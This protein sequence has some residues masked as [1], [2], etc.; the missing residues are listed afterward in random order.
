MLGVL[1]SVKS[2]V[3]LDSVCIDNNVFRLHYKLTFAILVTASL[4]V[5]ARQYVG[6]PIDCIVVE[7]PNSVMDTYCWVHSTYSVPNADMGKNHHNMAH[8]GIATD[9][10]LDPNAEVRYHKYY[11]W[12][13]FTLFFQALLFYIP[14]YLWKT[15]EGGKISLLLQD[16]NVPIVDADA[17]RERI[18]LLVE[19]FTTNKHNH[20]VYALKFFFCEILN[21]VNVFGQIYFTDLFLD[22][23]FTTY[24]T[25]VLAMSETDALDGVDPM[26]RIFPKMA[27]CTFHKFGPS[28]T[29]EKFDG[30]CVLPLNIINEKIYIFLWFWFII[31]CCVTG[32][33][34]LY[35]VVIMALPSLREVL[36]KTRGRLVPSF[37]T[38]AVSRKCQLGDWFILYQLAK[39][40]DPL[41]YRQFMDEMYKHLDNGEDGRRLID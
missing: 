3:K 2:F 29:V 16:L 38:E 33:Q 21:F 39:N 37:E 22:G 13:C 31:L 23:A 28:G 30:L 24:G 41:I 26:S 5:T 17:K 12:V 40:M 27:K 4:L 7:I 8:F 20:N 36:L 15:W 18:K 32:I 1:D 25:D 35:K 14:R 19:Y 6:D 34:I 9:N 10:D 11:Q